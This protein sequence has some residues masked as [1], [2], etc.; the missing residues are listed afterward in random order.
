MWE[1]EMVSEDTHLQ[2]PLRPDLLQQAQTALEERV[3]YPTVARGDSILRVLPLSGLEDFREAW[4]YAVASDLFHASMARQDHEAR[5]YEL[6]VVHLGGADILQRAAR[7]VPQGAAREWS[8]RLTQMHRSFVDQLVEELLEFS[9]GDPRYLVSSL[10]QDDGRSA[11]QFSSEDLAAGEVLGFA[12]RL[13]VQ[14]GIPPARDMRQ[15]SGTALTGVTAPA[16][17][18]RRANWTPAAERSSTDLERLRS[19]GYIGGS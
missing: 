8:R 18:G 19:L 6:V 3:R 15:G 14:L 12:P 1:G 4:E 7:R 16:S 10:F 5:A 11:M 2:H 13:L 9:P 17:W